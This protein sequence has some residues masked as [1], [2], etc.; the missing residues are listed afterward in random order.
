MITISLPV[1]E[2]PLQIFVDDLD[3]KEHNIC[4]ADRCLSQVCRGSEVPHCLY[5]PCDI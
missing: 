3:C 4:T 1:R 5:I 2:L